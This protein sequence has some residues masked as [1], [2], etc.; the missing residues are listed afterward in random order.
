MRVIWMWTHGS[1][2]NGS[3]LL[4]IV[5]AFCLTADLHRNQIITA[6]CETFKF[7][8]YPRCFIITL[9]MNG[10]FIEFQFVLNAPSSGGIT[11]LHH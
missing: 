1:T 10:Y 6:V 11:S 4:E 5:K 3:I 7:V 8:S 2:K 9:V